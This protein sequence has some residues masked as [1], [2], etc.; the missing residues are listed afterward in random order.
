MAREL[1]SVMSKGTR[2]YCHLDD[3]TLLSGSN[4]SI[5]NDN[6]S[7]GSGNVE[8]P[9]SLLVCIKERISYIPASSR[10]DDVDGD[11][12][13]TIDEVSSQQQ[14]G[15]TLAVPEY[16]VCCVDTTLGRRH[17]LLFIFF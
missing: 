4:S 13:T 1:C 17:L 14:H 12:T 8:E 7:T 3:L 10:N 15:R 9:K 2:T 5:I 11:N 6:N 16:G